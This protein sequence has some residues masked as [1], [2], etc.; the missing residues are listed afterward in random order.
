MD[1]IIDM[2]RGQV[3]AVCLFFH[4]ERG[5]LSGLYWT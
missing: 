3:Q 5:P 1:N 4:A 2:T